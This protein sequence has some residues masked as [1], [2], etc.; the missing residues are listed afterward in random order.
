NLSGAAYQVVVTDANGCQGTATVAVNATN[1]NMT[2]STSTTDA[3]CGVTDGTAIVIVTGGVAPYTY[4]WNDAINQ[5]TA[6]ATN[7]AAG[8][9]QVIVIDANGCQN[10]ATVT[11]VT[12][13]ATST[14]IL[15]TMTTNTTC[16]NR[17][18]TISLDI[19]G[20]TA[21]YTF[22]WDN[23]IGNIKDPNNLGAGVYRVVVTD[24]NGCSNTT[25]VIIAEEG[26][27]SVSLDTTN[28][29]CNGGNDGTATAMPDGGTAPYTYAWSNGGG[30]A[31]LTNLSAGTYTVTVT[32]AAGCQSIASSTLL[33][34]A[35]LTVSATP[36]G[37]DCINPN[38]SAIAMVTGGT[39]GYTFQWSDANN[40]ITQSVV[41]LAPGDYTVTVTDM[42]GCTA[43]ATTTIDPSM[44]LMVTLATTSTLCNGESSGAIMANVANGTAPFSY[45]WNNSLPDAASFTGL[46]Q[47][48]YQV[49]VTDANGC[50]GT[51]E[52]KVRGA[53]SLIVISVVEDA[54]CNADDGR[55]R[56]EVTGGA[57]PY[58]YVWDAPLNT[59]TSV[60]T[61]LTPGGYSFTVTDAN[62]CT[63]SDAIAVFRKTNCDT[64]KVVGGLINTSDSL[65]ICAG[66][67]IPDNITVNLTGNSGTNTSWIVTD[68]ALNILDL[69]SSNAFDFDGAGFGT[70][71]IWSVS[72]DNP[73]GGLIIGQNAANLTGC[74]ELSNKLVVVRQD[75]SP[76]DPCTV[77]PS[78]ITT[79]DSIVFC[80]GDGNAD[81][82]KVNLTNGTGA[83]SS[84]II[85]DTESNILD[86]STAT[87]YDFENTAAG[88]CLLWNITYEEDLTGLSVGS[89]INN[90][91][92]CYKL[93]NVL[94]IVK[95][96]CSTNCTDF[97]GSVTIN[98]P[99]G[100]NI[101]A[102][103]QVNLSTT[104]TETGLTYNWTA[105][106]GNFDS[107]TSATPTYSMMMPGT[108]Q[109]LVTV[110]KEE[111]VTRD[112]TTIT[113]LSGP[114]V[115]LTPTDI[116]C[117]GIND[118]LISTTVTGGTAP[119]TYSWSD[120]TI[121]NVANP[122]NLV[123]GTYNL[124]LTDANG[125]STTG[126]ATIN[127]GTTMTLN[128]TST[129]IACNATNQ[130]S[131]NTS[132]NGGTAP[133]TYIWSDNNLGNIPNPNNLTAGTYSLM[134]VDANGCSATDSVTINSG[135]MITVNLTPTNSV[136]GGSDAGSI[137]STVSGGTAPYTYSWNNGATS[138]ILENLVA[139]LYEVTVTD[140]NGCQGITNTT[141]NDGTNINI[142][143][144][145]TTPLCLDGNDGTIT[146]IISGGTAP[147]TYSWSNGINDVSTLTNLVAGTYNLTVTDAN[148][149]TVIGTATVNDGATIEVTLTPTA[150]FC[151]GVNDGN[152]SSTVSGGT[153]PYTY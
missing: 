56:L 119:Y 146:S 74:H 121:G 108:Y 92:G 144:V 112:S 43:T 93:S 84:F 116:A 69:P 107:S 81:S 126:S 10:R 62:G 128:L 63:Y 152:I 55:A 49:T 2:L 25:A 106:G 21:P 39:P 134:V 28:I 16:S 147:Y 61:G 60:V 38:G 82:V 58:T 111:C 148:D 143:L 5:Q 83:F 135:V 72:Y 29:S 40:Q 53:D 90:L 48:T 59:T 11:I 100:N 110:S 141:V 142:T 94:T 150:P 118:G 52:A 65:T 6:T 124:T 15:S 32:D 8:T 140:A 125:C 80:V 41:N 13:P 30:I 76:V 138:D 149:C 31:A 20:G 36:N 14:I 97:N 17:N 50:F 68:E 1:N 18:G 79:D 71:Y 95:Q 109:I 120:G 67:G 132:I 98:N 37:T 151:A 9:Y 33:N 77:T 27:F 123:A 75:C 12:N 87:I 139:G 26:A 86:I 117:Q 51:A 102:K 105:T 70:C 88:I 35:L 136:C 64:C 99:A 91:T 122:A 47:G 127:T 145:P 54:A 114:E 133:Y 23:D 101:C 44:G 115:N 19:N 4:A 66:D 103:A 130:G 46:S 34:T 24:A 22:V 89:T 3:S 42:N 113:I 7:L 45:T 131:I 96:D 104:S 129:D 153:A 85:T 78:S 137:T 73:I 57:S